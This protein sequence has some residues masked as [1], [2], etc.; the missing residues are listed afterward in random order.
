MR[1]YAVLKN[2]VRG[3]NFGVVV[4][5]HG[6][7][8]F[9]GWSEKGVEWS[10]WANENKV[11]L[12]Q[13]PANVSV[14]EFRGLSDQMMKSII[15]DS[16]ESVAAGESVAEGKIITFRL[17]GEA[18]PN[19]S[20]Y[21]SF[22]DGPIL[23][24][25]TSKVKSINFK[26]KNFRKEVA[27]NE[28]SL[29]VRMHE[30]AF[31]NHTK[32][33]VA[34]PNRA[35]KTYVRSEIQK[36]MSRGAERK[37]GQKIIG[38]V[39][40]GIQEASGL[41][42]I[43]RA[44]L[45]SNTKEI[46]DVYVKASLGR[47]IGRA[48]GSA[49]RGLTPNRGRARN[50]R[51]T[52]SRF[53]SGVLDPRKRRDVDGDGMIFDGTFREMPDPTRFIQKPN[54]PST[55]QGL[56]SSSRSNRLSQLLNEPDQRPTDGTI[57][58][59][60]I[61]DTRAR[62]RDREI[63]E[64]FG[65]TTE[66]TSRAARERGFDSSRRRQL[67]PVRTYMGSET[68]R[69]RGLRSSTIEKI[70]DSADG[71]NEDLLV[72]A[73]QKHRRGET[74][75]RGEKDYLLESLRNI[76]DN[77]PDISEDERVEL[78]DLERRV[79]AKSG[80]NTLRS[81]AGRTLASRG[82][83]PE[84]EDYRGLLN[85]ENMDDFRNLS[86]KLDAGQKIKISEDDEGNDLYN[87]YRGSISKTPSGKYEIEMYGSS[88]SWRDGNRDEPGEWSDEFDEWFDKQTYPNLETALLSVSDWD[89]VKSNQSLYPA[90]EVEALYGSKLDAVEE[91]RR[92]LSR[93]SDGEKNRGL[94]SS[95][96][97]KITDSA[98]GANEEELVDALSKIQRGES[99]TGDQRDYLLESLRN[100]LD[101]NP[102]ITE[103]ERVELI[104]LEN[105]IRNRPGGGRTLRSSGSSLKPKP[106]NPQ[107]NRDGSLVNVFDDF[108]TD[109]LFG[110]LGTHNKIIKQLEKWLNGEGPFPK[111]LNDWYR[112]RD[113]AEQFLRESRQERLKVIK[114]LKDRGY[115]SPNEARK[116][117]G[118]SKKKPAGSDNP[119]SQRK[120]PSK[121][122]LDAFIK[123]F[124][125]DLDEGRIVIGNRFSGAPV[126]SR[127]R[128]LPGREER[129]MQG[130][131]LRSSG[132]LDGIREMAD[133]AGEM[134]FVDALNKIR[135]GRDIPDDQMEY[136][137]E[138]VRNI[139][140][141]N[142]DITEDER[143]ALIDLE[144]RLN[145]SGNTLRSGGRRRPVQQQ[146]SSRRMLATTER[147]ARPRGTT[148]RSSGGTGDDT[149]RTPVPKSGATR[150]P[151]V[152]PG[153]KFGH[154]AMERKYGRDKMEGDGAVWDS[155]TPEQKKAVQEALEQEK[156]A[157]DKKLKS[158]FNKY[159]FAATKKG[160]KKQGV[161]AAYK[162]GKGKEGGRYEKR[163]E[164]DPLNSGD[165]S[166]MLLRLDQAVANGDIEK[167]EVSDKDSRELKLDEDGAATISNVKNGYKEQQQALDD[168]QTI[169]N[170]IEDG[171]FSAL[172]HLHPRVK[173][174]I[175]KIIK[176]KDGKVPKGWETG[177]SSIAGYAG[178]EQ[179]KKAPDAI[180]LKKERGI[181][182]KKKEKRLSL[183]QR[184][185]RMDPE[186]EK[187]IELR[188]ARR[189]GGIREGV[190]LDP[191]LAIKKRKLRARAMKRTMLSRF[192]KSRNA[193]ELAA[194]SK[195]RKDESGIVKTNPAENTLE[196]SDGFVDLLHALDNDLIGIQSKKR[197]GAT[198]KDV[199]NEHK[200]LLKRI[201]ENAGYA[202][203]PTLV[204]ED[205]VKALLDAGWQVMVRGTGHEKVDSESYVER[206]L[207]QE[208]RF[209]PG[210][211]GSAYGIG[212][213]FAYQG[214][215]EG[216][217]GS[218]QD[219]RHT[220]IAM[221][222]PTA[223]VM[224]HSEIK[225]EHSRMGD[226]TG[227]IIERFKV[228]GGRE[229]AKA[230]EPEEIVAEI[231]AVVPELA[232]EASR[233][234]Q[235]VKQLRD[236]MDA[237]S[238][239]PKGTQ[240]E[241]ARIA[242]TKEKLLSSIDYLYRFSKQRSPEMIAPIIGVDVIDTNNG[243]GMGTPMLLH[244]RTILAAFQAPAT[245]VQADAMI[246]DS[247]GARRP[248]AWTSWTRNAKQVGEA[249]R[250]PRRT[251]AGAKQ[252]TPT[253]PTPQTQAPQPPSTPSAP[254][255]PGGPVNTDAWKSSTPPTTGSNPAKMLTAPDGTRYYTK[256]RKNGETQKQAEERMQTEVLASK[257]YELAGVPTADLQM[258]TN[259]N[260]P[261]MLSRMLQNVRMPTGTSDNDEARKG[262]VVDAW[263][264]NWDAPLNDNILID[265]NG[266]AVRID[267]GG[268]LDFR[269][270]G[271]R[272][273]SGST[274]F[275]PSV[276]EMDTMQKD[277]T[278]DFR[279]MDSAELKRQ[280]QGLSVITDDDIRKTVS[281]VVTD[282]A[283]AKQLAD[284][285]IKRRD[286]I[287][288][289]YG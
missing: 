203:T 266:N 74:L 265:G 57:G 227:P 76:L 93:G 223:D 161:V 4:K 151:G 40:K 109:D 142:Q 100:I 110:R 61:T 287:T 94:R 149:T 91:V 134:D 39:N 254:N 73:L 165:V 62:A 47:A 15:L 233:S 173:K 116:E 5:S 72:T 268:S 84:Y 258:G 102:D 195:A 246:S 89:A 264:A 51:G 176:D 106:S 131:T 18:N 129:L 251:R 1:Q 221:I 130:R 68:R 75:S 53:I 259:N 201:W 36:K 167:F 32:Q 148:L 231:D 25:W 244:N 133:G 194:D 255:A 108:E 49:G 222:P 162:R 66:E 45:G 160:A 252:N 55:R 225:Q 77:N 8:K 198:E 139:L 79:G 86:E 288:S 236:R 191:E 30:L 208:G 280:A 179:R 277:G 274:P 34:K 226:L 59:N 71:A 6:H 210:Q 229:A 245:K 205:E 240:E 83:Q 7:L 228:L 253:Q 158:F 186:R 56:R 11:D 190:A 135:D 145:P 185:R 239:M 256:L 212:E 163:P 279:N 105:S 154:G 217:H 64:I 166:E 261:V 101:N 197:K 214:E 188:A 111:S 112:D 24:D 174:K 238:K 286:D 141:N 184:L 33:F 16:D 207:T 14:G 63:R 119:L 169:L 156:K 289:R 37:F 126:G 23:A 67:Q 13:L 216:Y 168:A 140:D 44:E 250:R 183:F 230:M 182:E 123:K 199:E 248:K 157:I 115:E 65:R 22:V 275:G 276:G 125:R 263:L 209:I 153:G 143:V 97:K 278:Y 21:P 242:E 147:A 114:A 260:E 285:L 70:I 38:Q 257:L 28:I 85:V 152:G 87:T 78:I 12:T 281:A 50:M 31:N 159:W 283:R 224:M 170:M 2:V 127:T 137:R 262:F 26:A 52:A 178:G 241:Q 284:T 132:N 189:A 234:G 211:G 128:K 3:V 155:L 206:F 235:I 175:A 48:A 10:K 150:G 122:P 220:I 104:D 136:L 92:A 120:P 200:T 249:K 204:K 82:S 146:L 213:Y 117:Y 27:H 282:P 273:G 219:D 81:R 271:A 103:D 9:Y 171:D 243:S 187:A 58:Y 42:T 218:G 121:D 35:T 124:Q 113:R 43:K 99:V 267:V 164:E 177:S 269:A 60:P 54:A 144:K 192:R 237:L 247:N 180:D 19:T 118:R 272:K 138:T 80:K 96:L 29:K 90:D 98:E 69:N 232:S 193:D 95:T 181:S 196:I 202:E 41:P 215:W 172:E 20:K 88:Q 46:I 107:R 17:K 270:Q